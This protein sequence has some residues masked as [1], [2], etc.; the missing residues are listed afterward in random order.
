ME[1]MR[2]RGRRLH[3][4]LPLLVGD[5]ALHRIRN[6]RDHQG[7]CQRHDRHVHSEH[8]WNFGEFSL[9]LFIGCEL[10]NRRKSKVRVS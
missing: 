4:N 9:A 1:A 5:A 7:V 3:L 8:F 6:P 10:V 2:L